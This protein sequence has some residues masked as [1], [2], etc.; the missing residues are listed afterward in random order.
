MSGPTTCP[1]IPTKETISGERQKRRLI[2]T[3]PGAHHGMM[4]VST[5]ALVCA[6]EI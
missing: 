4:K 3:T 5:S 2:I 6:D 1:N